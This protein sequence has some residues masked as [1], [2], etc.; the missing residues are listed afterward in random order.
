MPTFCVGISHVMP[1]IQADLI[2][3][4]HICIHDSKFC[5]FVYELAYKHFSRRC[6]WRCFLRAD[7]AS[8]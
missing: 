4:S 2:L 8:S 3:I 7:S 5:V 6:E 1:P